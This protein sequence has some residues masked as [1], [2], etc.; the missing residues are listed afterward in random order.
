MPARFN[1]LSRKALDRQLVAAR[2]LLASP[3]PRDG[4]LATIREALGMS[5]TDWAGRLGV[6][7]R[8]AA[9]MEDRELSGGITLRNL[10][11]AAGALGCHVV[12]AVVPETSLEEQ[13]R[14]QAM[15]AARRLV[16]DVE[17]SMALEE[18]AT[19]ATAREERVR[20]LA[21]EM[22]RRNDR[23]LWSEPH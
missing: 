12:Y 10:E 8:A 3:R 19:D 4:W 9:Q 16:A 6:S 7:G 1:T 13:V 11:K 23:R 20:E 2:E 22:I 17:H 21:S 15:R 5:L 14:A 18:Q